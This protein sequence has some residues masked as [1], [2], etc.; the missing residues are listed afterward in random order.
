MFKIV[1]AVYHDL[2][3]EARSSEVLQALQL[4]GEVH[5]ISYADIPEKYK[6]NS[7]KVYIAKQKGN[8]PGTRFF[9]FVELTRK[10]IN[11]ENPNMVLFHDFSL[12]VKMVKKR[13]SNTIIAYDQ[14]ELVIDRKIKSLKT[15]ILSLFDYNEKKIL[16]NIDIYIAA[17]KDRAEIAKKYFDLKNDI[18]VFDNMHK[19][20]SFCDKKE[21]ESKFGK[22]FSKDVFT[23]VYG[24]GIRDDRGTYEL[25]AAVGKLGNNYRL[26]V[27]GNDWG[28]SSKFKKYLLENNITNVSYIGFVKREEWG[29]LLTRANAS[30]VFFLQNTLNNKYCASGKMYESLFL[31]KPII[32]STNPPLVSLCNEFNCGVYGDNLESA[33]LELKENY[34]KYCKGAVKFSKSVDYD[35]RLTDLSN[36]IKKSIIKRGI[37]I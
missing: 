1:Y 19:I 7:T 9:S 5:I 14:S 21:G 33:I 13:H 8:I 2:N 35:S 34:D 4:L 27:A 36:A 28:N 16:K 22:L 29:Y 6:N 12:L 15:F 26:I 32:C 10:T 31:G 30:T 18:L 37:S 25:S 3:S 20:D 11:M 24:G 23:I 17:N